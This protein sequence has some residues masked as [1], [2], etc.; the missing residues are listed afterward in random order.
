[1]S[2][3]KEKFNII[4]IVF[5]I[6]IISL[7]QI[8]EK[9][10]NRCIVMVFLYCIFKF[11]IYNRYL[12][13]DRLIL[14][15]TMS[16]GILIMISNMINYNLANK[17]YGITMILTAIV[18]FQLTVIFG[19]KYIENGLI[20]ISRIM[21]IVNIY[22]VIE[23][24][25][26]KNIFTQFFKDEN[27]KTYSF[28]FNDS[29]Y[30]TSAIFAHAIVYASILLILFWINLLLENK[31]SLKIINLM[32][33][34]LDL[35]T[36][37]SRSIWIAFSITLILYI[38]TNSKFIQELIKNK[39]IKKHNFIIIWIS[40]ILAMLSIKL[41]VV[42]NI[43]FSII[44]RFGEI[45]TSDG[46]VSSQQRLLSIKYIIKYMYNSNIFNFLAGYGP[47]TSSYVMSSTTIIIDGFTTT[48]N[49]FASFF[50]EIG[51]IG[52]IMLLLLSFVLF[53]K[54]FKKGNK[55]YAY[56]ILVAL[57]LSMF[58]YELFH[59]YVVSNFYFIL[60]GSVV[61]KDK[62]PRECN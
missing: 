16:L 33:I 27:M 26:K 58:F 7:F 54:T 15:I 9:L 2:N 49:Q 11:F 50:I 55:L 56:I 60:L 12:E 10:Y 51:I 13:K 1:M 41:E 46:L 36:T 5:I 31:K 17:T 14:Y 57:S 37:K 21:I 35:Y 43:I 20:Q 42:Q 38:L 3:I 4:T 34:I 18:G 44:G 53:I 25:T 23:F 52:L 48:D 47:G 30:R 32:L 29:N 61:V 28:W 45:F 19:K 40:L 62:R 24:I 59:W 39:K 8:D 22:G 6:S